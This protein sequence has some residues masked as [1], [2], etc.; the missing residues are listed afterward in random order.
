MS[1]T[2]RFLQMLFGTEMTGFI[3]VR[4]IEEKTKEMEAA[5]Q[6]SKVVGRY[7]YR[8][9]EA[10]LSALE[11]LLEQAK[12]HNAAVFFGVLRRRE[13]GKG[14]AADVLPGWIIWIDL[15]AKDFSDGMEGVRRA[16]A[17]YPIPPSIVVLTAHGLHAYWLLREEHDPAELSAV[18]K[19][20]ANAL[21]GDH[22]FDAARIL[23]LPDTYNRKDPAHPIL[24]TIEKLEPELRSN[25][26]EHTEALDMLGGAATV[27]SPD[28][29]PLPAGTDN[30]A[31]ASAAPAHVTIA[32][33]ISPAV[34]ALLTYDTKV[35]GYFHGHGKRE[36]DEHGKPLDDSS[37]GYDFSL[38][39]SLIRNGVTAPSELG[40]ALWHRPDG[41]ARTKG[42]DY[43]ARTVQR[44]LAT[45]NGDSSGAPPPLGFKV[46][47]V[48]IYE[49]NP[50]RFVFVI[51]GVELKLTAQDLRSVGAF[52]LRFLEGLHRVPQ[53]R[54]KPARWDAM[55]ND[56]LRNAVKI[57]MPPEASEDGALREAVERA[58]ED[59]PLQEVAELD[60]RIARGRFALEDG[61]IA[62]RGEAL[63]GRVVSMTPQVSPQAVYTV[64]HQIGCVEYAPRIAGKRVRLWLVPDPNERAR[65]GDANDAA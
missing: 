50:P 40:T 7:W 19:R 63:V 22:T 65:G 5:D 16:L 29:S 55:V 26:S 59:M 44:A 20:M 45:A 51:D 34:Q 38:V 9:P 21:N 13:K 24:V 23:R 52:S 57:W 18:S 6:K 31:P 1:P 11:F 10:F 53:L 15:D 30:T 43:I 32:D 2:L 47:R 46:E 33:A 17:S 64:M 14:K 49:M 3:E 28:R 37:S 36:R 60:V 61:R 42:A 54:V 25:L 35:H 58:L 12:I 41:A 48:T 8:S 4:L 62:F 27:L 39:L 56:W